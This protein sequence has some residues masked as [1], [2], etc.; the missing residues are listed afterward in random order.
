MTPLDMARNCADSVHRY[1]EQAGDPVTACTERLGDRQH[2]AARLGAH[3]ALISIA[4]DI[5]RIADHLAGGEGD[6]R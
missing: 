5:R 4:A 1:A 3:L 2:A 6:S